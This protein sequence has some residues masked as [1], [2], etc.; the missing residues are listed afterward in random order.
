MTYLIILTHKTFGD[1]QH[2]RHRIPATPE[3]GLPEAAS[4][5]AGNSNA[6]LQ[7]GEAYLQDSTLPDPL[8]EQLPLLQ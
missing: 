3:A 6:I 7:N 4:N 8:R 1:T 2:L 5:T